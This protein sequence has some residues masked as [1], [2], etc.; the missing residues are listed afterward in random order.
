MLHNIDSLPANKLNRLEIELDGMKLPELALNNIH[1]SNNDPNEMISYR[2]NADGNVK[3]YRSDGLLV[4]TAAG[5]TAW[6]YNLG[7]CIMTL[8]LT[9]MQYL[10]KGL[11]NEG[12][13]FANELDV[14]PYIREGIACIDVSYITYKFTLGS[15]IKIRKGEPLTLL[16]DIDTKR[17]Y[18]LK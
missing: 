9:E 17:D 14:K 16:G 7:G 8:S 3:D 11:R 12:P 1:L 4:S 13:R 6:M 5:S 15:I 18:Y 2:L 10:S